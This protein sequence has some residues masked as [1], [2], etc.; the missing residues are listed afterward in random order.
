MPVGSRD[1]V[2]IIHAHQA[3]HS[4]YS[5]SGCGDYDYLFIID[6]ILTNE[7][8][9]IVEYGSGYSTWLINELINDY[10]LDIYLISH[11]D[12]QQYLEWILANLYV[13]REVI[14]L[15]PVKACPE[16]DTDIFK[17]GKYND[18]LEA[19]PEVEM[20]ITDGPGPCQA[21]DFNVTDNY[22]LIC[23]YQDTKI[24]HWIDGR[25]FTKQYYRELG[26]GDKI[27]H[28]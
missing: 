14:N 18:N 6:Y 1:Y 23:E 26:Y 8:K 2:K 5:S 13:P 16:L 7:P 28:Y 21:G 24:P 22:R 20:V 9:C 11:E 12:S 4:E 19:Y 27:L 3:K 15:T 10:K 25:K 17:V